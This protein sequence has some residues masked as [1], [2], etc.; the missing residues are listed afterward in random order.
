MHESNLYH[1]LAFAGYAFVLMTIAGNVRVKMM[2][3]VSSLIQMGVLL[4][5][6][7]LLLGFFIV[8]RVYDN[9]QSA[10]W[11]TKSVYGMPLL[12]V[13]SLWWMRRTR[14]RVAIDRD[15]EEND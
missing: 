1:L 8:E 7:D 3:N 9:H 5:C 13:F 15:Q 6:I 4:L 14:K 12:V 11:M 2:R 10:G